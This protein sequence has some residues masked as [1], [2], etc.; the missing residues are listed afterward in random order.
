MTNRVV[1]I[2][3]AR[4]SEVLFFKLANKAVRERLGC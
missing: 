1:G 2:C 3:R 4:D